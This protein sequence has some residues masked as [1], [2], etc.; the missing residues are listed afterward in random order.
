MQFPPMTLTWYGG[1][2]VPDS[3]NVQAI[4]KAHA[5][6]TI[7]ICTKMPTTLVTSYLQRQNTKQSNQMTHTG[8]WELFYGIQF[9]MKEKLLILL[10]ANQ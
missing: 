1:F 2:C 5:H 9:A 3:G 10:R 4:E 7:W 6:Q 8:L